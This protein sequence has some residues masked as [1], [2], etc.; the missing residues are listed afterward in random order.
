MELM[1][2]KTVQ[3]FCS[4]ISN[5]CGGRP[6]ERSTVAKFM[7]RHA[8]TF[9]KFGHRVR[10]AARLDRLPVRLCDDMQAVVR[11]NTEF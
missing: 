10:Q 1:P 9:Q 3:D 5:N 11:P 4:L 2:A 8:P 6:G 7:K